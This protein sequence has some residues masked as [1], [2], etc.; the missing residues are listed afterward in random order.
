MNPTQLAVPQQ[1]MREAFYDGGPGMLVSGTVWAVAALVCHLQGV[2]RGI[3][4]LLIGGALIHPMSVLLTKALGRP[5]ASPKD[6]GLPTLAGTSTVWLIV[7]C[8]MAY[9]L[10]RH[11]VEWFFPAMMATIGSRYLVFATLFGRAVYLVCGG[12]LVVAGVAAVWLHLQPVIAAALGSGIEV[13]FA[14]VVF[15]GAAR[16]QAN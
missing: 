8:A 16:V 13:V 7:C 10:S 2:E 14:A 15:K 4:A 5:A 1:A 3:W 9:G 11:N 6:N 12:V